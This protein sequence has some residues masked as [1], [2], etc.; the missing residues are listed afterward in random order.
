MVNILKAEY[1]KGLT[2]QQDQQPYEYNEP[3]FSESYSSRN[4]CN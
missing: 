2:E 4:N 3:I 1:S